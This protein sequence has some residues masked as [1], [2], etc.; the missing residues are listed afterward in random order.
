MNKETVQLTMQKCKGSW[1]FFKQLYV[2]E[3]HKLGEMDK[4]L[5]RYSLRTLNQEETEYMNRP[6]QVKKLNLW[7]KIFKQM[8]V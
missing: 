8:K 4:F 1:D 3:K 7:L 5:E 6:I 2:N